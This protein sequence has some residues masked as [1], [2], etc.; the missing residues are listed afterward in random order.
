MRYFNYFKKRFCLPLLFV[1]GLNFGL[2][3]NLNIT[4][5]GGETGTSGSN[6]SLTGN[7]LTVT[8]T[9]NIRASVIVNALANGNLTVV[10]NTSTFSV[11]V[12]EAITA[13][14]NNTLTVGSATNTGT[15]TFNAVTS[16]AGP[17]NLY[18]GSINMDQNMTCTSSG[19]PILLQ[20]TGA[21]DIAA[22]RKV[23][24]NS[25]NITLRSNS[26]GTVLSNASSIILNNS[27]SLLSQGGNITLGGNFTGAQGT[28][29]YAT[30]GNAPA[31][32]IDG[33]TISAA[34]GNIKLYGKCDVFYDD[35][36]RLTG[37]INTTGIGTIELYGEAYGGV[38][39]SNTFF[40]GV[41]FG[42]EN[43]TVSTVNGNLTIEGILTNTNS[44]SASG[45]NFY[46]NAGGNG[47][48]S[49]QL[50]S[51]TGNIQVSGR[52]APSAA[53]KGIGQCS[54]GNVYIGSPK[55]NSWTA[56]GNIIMSLSSFD[57]A[58]ET[59]IIFKTMGALNV[60]P[61][62]ASFN[63]SLT[64]PF[65]DNSS[66]S[67]VSAFTMGKASNTANITIGA[68][69]ISVAGPITLY[70]GTLSL[71]ANI[72]STAGGEIALYSDAALAGLSSA[73]SM[74]T[75]GA[76]RYLPQGTSFSSTVTFPINN[77]SLV[78][79]TE[80]QLGKSGNTAGITIGSS[81]TIAGNIYIYG[82]IL[83]LNG[84][85]TATNDGNIFLNSDNAIAGLL[86]QRNV[87]AAGS[88]NYISQ[89]NSFATAITFPIANLN[90]SCTG[91][92]I[93]K[94]SNATNI[95]FDSNTSIAGP[96][97]AYGGTITLNANLTTTN[98]GDISLYTDNALGGL[99]VART[100]NA[101]G[102]FN[103]IPR[104]DFFS[105]PVTYPISNLNLTSSGLLI[106]KPSNTANITFANATTVAGPI[107]AYGGT[108][109]LDADLTTT[110]NGAISLYTDNALGGLS[111]ARTLTAAGAFK[112]IP[113]GT[114]FS[115]DVTYPIANLTAT[116]TGL[117]I[118]NSTN[119]KNITINAD[120]TG[121]A[122]IELYGNNV[123]IN[124]NLTTTGTSAIMHL[125][126]NTTIAAGKTITSG[127]NFTHDGNLTFKSDVNGTAAFGTLGSGSTFTTVSGLA[128]TERYVPSKR[129]WR[130]LTAP[131]KGATNNTIPANWQG[132][133][134]EGLLFF[135]PSTYQ[136]Q[137]M[138]GYTTGGG[139]PNIWKYDSVTTQWQSI[140]NLTTENLFT[141]TG[142]N[143][144]L[145]FATGPS[146]STNIASGATETTLR[147]EGQLI[148][149]N[150]THSLTAD[151]YHLIG[152]PYASPL[153]TEAMVQANANTKVF[154]V[155]P[156]IGTVGGYVTYD[157]SNWTPTPPSG[158]EKYIQSGQG[159]FVRSTSNTTF[160]ISE[161]NKVVG[162]S[163]TWFDRASSSANT[164]S[165]SSVEADKI[166]VL[167]YKQV[168][169]QWQLA[170]G[171]LTVNSATGNN[172]VDATDTEK[173]S[174]F[175]ENI[176]FRNGTSTLAIEYRG[177]PTIGTIQP[178]RLTGTTVQPYQLRVK[179]ENYSNSDLQ[180]YVEDT[181]TGV[182][183]LIPID[184]SEV[185]VHF[186]GIAATTTAPDSRFR[187][188]YPA[189]LSSDDPTTS[190]SVGIYPNPVE[191]KM[192]TIV[193][194]NQ[195]ETT[196]YTLTNLLGQQ[197]QQ[198]KLD[199]LQNT[200]SVVSL[201][202]GV[203]VLQVVQSGKTFTTKLI[204]K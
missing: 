80:L 13:T 188:V 11:T 73:R 119:D 156:T 20:S 48:L 66:I 201:Q 53:S 71:G 135:S 110:N 179:T 100:I 138:T 128:T 51:K 54:Q 15:I 24:S 134:D 167:L 56:T 50:L 81:A 194:A 17:V 165:S 108:I 41:T 61:Y 93:G 139:M 180:P 202:G 122:G 59:G 14:G 18:G 204:I 196:Q 114:T 150:V 152:N 193:L 31:I 147:P 184:G 170:D 4:S 169:S 124:S 142:N 65:S 67:G 19:S 40:G 72:T 146:N 27:S 99:S 181:Q 189:T 29:L 163:N 33:G 127:G 197:V 191:D 36:I 32:L 145:V 105:A 143:G 6:W 159:F 161:S 43:T 85:L 192:F 90:V 162:N 94:L 112:Y 69:G 164:S 88:F 74:T 172:D 47:S 64:F 5:S 7:T 158:S 35:G 79:I 176:G 84:N 2:A 113:R 92:L 21:I 1:L 136:S 148:T 10:G 153:H 23:Q 118:G 38:S 182:L 130:L 12:S 102:S 77:L 8:G 166:R 177:L 49:I 63:E 155:D 200:V 75:T 157:G 70:G 58:I 141:S 109:T 97:T 144:F 37:T 52:K 123:N 96:I 26:G 132:V 106:G 203:Y 103:Y 46:R 116:S 117:T 187:I 160:T 91:L 44:S 76:F 198:G 185:V 168:D 111:T 178:M 133:N 131:L 126:G 95:S 98:Y 173:M 175:N 87:T 86:V 149:G 57:L 39:G 62:D 34:G 190:L 42:T 174:N 107:T 89:S 195:D 151:K 60:E 140:P 125:K 199:T 121:G 16:F 101:S 120:V 82:G 104:S 28:G 171:I 83:T 25:G 22:S 183:T 45:L 115:A 3:Q 55:D 186:T 154:M 30:S 129:G 9:A 68:P 137:A 78:D